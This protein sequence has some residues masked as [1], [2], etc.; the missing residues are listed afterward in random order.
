[1]WITAKKDW[2][3]AQRRTKE[4]ERPVA[5]PPKHTAVHPEV[6]LPISN[7]VVSGP[8]PELGSEA[9]TPLQNSETSPDSAAYQPEMDE[10]RCILY[11]HGG[12]DPLILSCW[13][14]VLCTR[15][16]LLWQR[17]SGTV[18]SSLHAC[19]RPALAYLTIICSKPLHPALCS[20]DTRTRPR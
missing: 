13:F 9:S 18:S 19:D 15:W 11:A 2:Q 14:N 1:M 6:H 17:G 16:L 20:K 4:R 12:T 8:P 7:G 5:S 3:N 10:M